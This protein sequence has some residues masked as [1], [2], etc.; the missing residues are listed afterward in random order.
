[1]F[2]YIDTL[3]FSFTLSTSFK[4]YKHFINMF[5]TL[6]LLLSTENDSLSTKLS[7]E[8][9]NLSTITC[10]AAVRSALVLP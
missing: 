1:M 3:L 10:S 9:R 2:I 8:K 5:S 6:K 7:T 4:I